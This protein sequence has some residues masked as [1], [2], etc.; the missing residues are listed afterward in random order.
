MDRNEIVWVL[1]CCLLNLDHVSKIDMVRFGSPEKL[2]EMGIKL[3]SSLQNKEII[4]REML[5]G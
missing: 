1:E 2:A 3:C 4:E 5:N